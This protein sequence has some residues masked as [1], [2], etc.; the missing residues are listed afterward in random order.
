MIGFNCEAGHT[1]NMS[2]GLR[3]QVRT[4]PSS[5]VE[6]YTSGPETLGSA[7]SQDTYML[8]EH[9]FCSVSAC[10]MLDTFHV[11]HAVIYLSMAE[12]KGTMHNSDQG[13]RGIGC[14]K[15]SRVNRTE[16]NRME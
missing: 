8:A 9:G 7:V 12:L 2:I 6:L 11:W 5:S 15:W 10:H 4:Y 13:N 16:Q 1:Q 3:H 14:Q